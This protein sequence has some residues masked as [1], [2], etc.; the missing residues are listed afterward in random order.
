MWQTKFLKLFKC[1]Q[2]TCSLME[3]Y[4]NILLRE[5]FPGKREHMKSIYKKGE[6]KFQ[7]QETGS[8]NKFTQK[9]YV[10]SAESYQVRV[11]LQRFTFLF[12]FIS[13]NVQPTCWALEATSFNMLHEEFSL[14]LM[15]KDLKWLKFIRILRGLR[16]LE[17][18]KVINKG[19]IRFLDL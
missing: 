17:I 15:T 9:F 8:A 14:K 3:N 11:F 7:Y 13:C 6:N 19:E 2:S 10:F 5:N 4:L 16:I 1:S 12:Y 18:T